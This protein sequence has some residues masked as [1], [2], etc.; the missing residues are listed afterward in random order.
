MLR[1]WFVI[2]L[3]K[4]FQLHGLGPT[5]GET[6]KLEFYVPW[7]CVVLYSVHILIGPA[8]I[9]I[10]TILCF[11]KIC[12]CAFCPVHWLYIQIEHKLAFNCFLGTLNWK[13]RRKNWFSIIISYLYCLCECLL[14]CGFKVAPAEWSHVSYQHQVFVVPSHF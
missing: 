4:L 5:V 12:I 10:R 3:T 9:S 1:Y 6:V 7:I 2:Y 11:P 14:F 8:R 13:S